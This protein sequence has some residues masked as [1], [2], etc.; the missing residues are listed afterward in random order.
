MITTQYVN[1][2]GK[3]YAV[4][5]RADGTTDIYVQWEAFNLADRHFVRNSPILR[6]TSVSPHGRLG[7]R[8]LTALAA[9]LRERICTPV[10]V[11][12]AARLLAEA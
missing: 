6:T 9:P 7:K 2:D 1:L 8:V 3:Q 10:S 11:D 4:R 12:A 5:Q